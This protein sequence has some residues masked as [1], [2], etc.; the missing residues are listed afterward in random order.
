[1]RR[2]AGPR[3]ADAQCAVLAG[4]HQRTALRRLAQIPCA[5]PLGHEPEGDVVPKQI[6]T[7]GIE[8]EPAVSH[9]LSVDGPIELERPRGLHELRA[10]DYGNPAQVESPARVVDHYGRARVSERIPRLA[11]L[12]AGRQ[13]ERLA[14]PY[15]PHAH[16]VR[17]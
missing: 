2:V 7:H 11:C 8:R 3:L 14:V 1:M 5:D 6:L 12:A 10:P 9:V 4:L 17:R 16:D 13:E 15:E